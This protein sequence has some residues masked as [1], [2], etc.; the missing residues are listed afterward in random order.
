ML[1]Q[2]WR[3]ASAAELWAAATAHNVGM[4]QGLT[5]K[6]AHP[7]TST[8]VWAVANGCHAVVMQGCGL[9]DFSALSAACTASFGAVHDVGR[10]LLPFWAGEE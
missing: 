7:L 6:R 9:G 8:R 10:A 1:C 4:D 5:C 3:A 2:S